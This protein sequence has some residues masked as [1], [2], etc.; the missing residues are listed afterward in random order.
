M[1]VVK[2][3]WVGFRGEEGWGIPEA[4]VRHMVSAF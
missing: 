2:I 1:G 3:K 4:T